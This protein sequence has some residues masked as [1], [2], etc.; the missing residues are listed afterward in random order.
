MGFTRSFRVLKNNGILQQPNL[1]ERYLPKMYKGDAV[2]YT[3]VATNE[4]VY[5]YGFRTVSRTTYRR[6]L[7]LGKCQ[8]MVITFGQGTTPELVEDYTLDQ[9]FTENNSSLTPV[10]LEQE[11]TYDAEKLTH[12]CTVREAVSIPEGGTAITIKEYGIAVNV[13][14]NTSTNYND[15][16]YSTAFNDIFNDVNT[17]N[18]SFVMIYREVLPEDQWI[19]INP[20]ETREFSFTIP[21]I[22]AGYA[23]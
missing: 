4:Y 8:Q 20:G 23:R 12:T 21:D 18:K 15:D 14:S 22:E 9:P 7:A 10:Y 2:R 17:D 5:Y 3:E 16:R 13:D 1:A 11:L 19:T 6:F